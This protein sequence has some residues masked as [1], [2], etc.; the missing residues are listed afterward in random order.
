MMLPAAAQ[1]LPRRWYPLLR[2]T[3]SF[4]VLGIVGA[5]MLA[6]AVGNYT[7]VQQ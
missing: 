5:V 4:K 7:L 1:P 2:L 3:L 6:Y